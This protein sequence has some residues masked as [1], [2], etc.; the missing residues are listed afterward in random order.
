MNLNIMEKILVVFNSFFSSFMSIEILLIGFL[1]FI[2]LILNAK[3]N[4]KLVK[5]F[6]T[7]IYL[8]FFTFI[9]IYYQDYVIQSVDGLLKYIMKY[10]YFPSLAMYF[11]LM[12]FVTLGM[13]YT[14]FSIRISSF[15]KYLNI[16]IFSLLHILY[17]QVIGLVVQ[18]KIYFTTDVEI[19]KNETILSLVQIS[20]LLLL[21]WI[22][23]MIFYQ[24]YQ[25]LRRKFDERKE[26]I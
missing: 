2:F 18:D 3:K 6:I 15:L 12:V 19:Y 24:I 14:M 20:N 25:Y 10:I 22:L 4:V 11:I 9:C 23:I 1:L 26:I 7:F 5:F 13:I 21:I 17:F 8:A 16:C